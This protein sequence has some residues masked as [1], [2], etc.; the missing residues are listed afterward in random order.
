MPRFFF[1]V[2]NG[3][4]LIEDE[5][6]RDLPDIERVQTEAIK[7]IRSIVSDEALKGCIDLRGRI[8]IA[9]VDG[10]VILTIPFED[11]FTIMRGSA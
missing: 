3:V 4:G 1:H 2:D 5:G 11:A 10:T 9:D 6:G 7:G 8:A